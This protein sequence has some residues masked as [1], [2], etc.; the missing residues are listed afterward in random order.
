MGMSR[1][2]HPGYRSDAWGSGRNFVEVPLA[3]PIYNGKRAVELRP[4]KG[5]D[6]R[7]RRGVVFWW[8][9]TNPPKRCPL[10]GAQLFIMN[11]EVIVYW[12]IDYYIWCFTLSS[13]TLN[14][15]TGRFL[16]FLSSLVN[17]DRAQAWS[18]PYPGNCSSETRNCN[19]TVPHS[20]SVHGGPVWL[21]HHDY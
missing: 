15:F 5:P 19:F 11:Q 6:A 3:T 20:A 13:I 10:G 21:Y 18:V 9:V 4:W 8:R 16:F 2:R 17:L 1:C 14:T 7:H 12:V